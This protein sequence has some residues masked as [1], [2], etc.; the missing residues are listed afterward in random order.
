MLIALLLTVYV[1]LSVYIGLGMFA[2][3]KS[4]GRSTLKSIELALAMNFLWP[5]MYLL[6]TIG[7]FLAILLVII[8]EEL[9]AAIW[10]RSVEPKD[11][12]DLDEDDHGEFQYLE[13]LEDEQGVENYNY[14]RGWCNI[15]EGYHK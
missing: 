14:T 6:F 12:D 10:G 11:D 4:T 9:S 1:L 2:I 3:S 7:F 8:P 13:D 15:C 5:I